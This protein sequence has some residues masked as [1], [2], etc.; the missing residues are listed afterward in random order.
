MQ[1]SDDEIR[2]WRRLEDGD[3]CIMGNT[4]DHRRDS[5]LTIPHFKGVQSRLLL[6]PASALS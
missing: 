3:K 4:N 2:N 1:Q 6:S 5:L